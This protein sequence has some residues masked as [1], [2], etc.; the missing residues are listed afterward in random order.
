M[1]CC[2]N[3]YNQI[4]TVYYIY[5]LYGVY[6]IYRVLLIII[7]NNLTLLYYIV[8]GVNKYSKENLVTLFIK[9]PDHY[10][11]D[12]CISDRHIYLVCVE[13]LSGV[14]HLLDAARCGDLKKVQRLVSSDLYAPSLHV[15]S[16]DSFG[17]TALICACWKGHVDLVKW[18]V[19]EATADVNI[20]N[21]SG[22]TALMAATQC[23]HL[24]IVR[25][26]IV[27]AGVSVT[28]TNNVCMSI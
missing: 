23:E 28:A 27:D 4:F 14:Q 2:S 13:M 15:N 20:Q 21:R 9:Y 26:L 17:N 7:Y 3:V 18:L 25:F 11:I 12:S 6:H 16:Q 10:I 5:Y 19:H 22:E 1:C 24:R 8:V